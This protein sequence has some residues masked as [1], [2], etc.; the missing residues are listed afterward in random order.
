MENSSHNYYKILP[1]AMT[2]EFFTGNHS[3][4]LDDKGR[5]SLPIPYREKLG[6]RCFVSLQ[7]ANPC[8]GVWT[9]EEFHQTLLRLE[10]AARNTEAS[11]IKE[12]QN[13]L[14]LFAGDALEVRQ[15]RSGRIMLPVTH[16]KAADLKHE[17]LVCGSVHRIEIW[18]PKKWA[19]IAKG[20]EET[21]ET[22]L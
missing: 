2:S 18:N 8:V 13:Q 11:N 16:R 15:D 9:V 1:T 6:D 10:D 5:V 7:R 14:R 3:R 21:E 17:V 20:L 19:D 12:R 22:W 4:T